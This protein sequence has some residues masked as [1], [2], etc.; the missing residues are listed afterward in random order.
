MYQG[1]NISY[2]CNIFEAV[3]LT[4]PG[5][6]YFVYIH[7]CIQFQCEKFMKCQ[8]TYMTAKHGKLK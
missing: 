8:K 7:N 6:Y 1:T 2:K 5:H 3:N 4:L